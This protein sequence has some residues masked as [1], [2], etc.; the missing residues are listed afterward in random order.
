[1][2]QLVSFKADMQLEEKEFLRIVFR[3]RDRVC[4]YI[5]MHNIPGD[6]CNGYNTYCEKFDHWSKVWFSS[7][8]FRILR[9]SSGIHDDRTSHDEAHATNVIANPAER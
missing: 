8:E 1:M 2:A 7:P 4:I 3:F 6:Y 5:Y 9:D